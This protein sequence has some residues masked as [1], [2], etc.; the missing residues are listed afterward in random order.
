MSKYYEGPQG[1]ASITRE[2]M[3]DAWLAF[4]RDYTDA[5]VKRTRRVVDTACVVGGIAFALMVGN[6]AKDRVDNWGEGLIEQTQA[7]DAI[8]NDEALALSSRPDF[9]VTEPL[10]IR[11]P[12]EIDPGIA[13]AATVSVTLSCDS[14]AGY[15]SKTQQAGALVI[16]KN[17]TE[18]VTSPRIFSTPINSDK[19]IVDAEIAEGTPDQ[20]YDGFKIKLTLSYFEP[21]MGATDQGPVSA[22]LPEWAT[23]AMTDAIQSGRIQPLI[24]PTE[25]GPPGQLEPSLI[26]GNSGAIVLRNPE[27]GIGPHYDSAGKIMTAGFSILDAFSE[28]VGFRTAQDV[29]SQ[30]EAAAVLNM[31]KVANVTNEGFGIIDDIAGTCSKY[32]SVALFRPD[33]GLDK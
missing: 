22:P 29:C 11:T 14:K 3:D 4:D 27:T 10:I 19:C 30:N 2:E 25:L 24:I 26:H 13:N 32:G 9:S 12:R 17:Q 18:L 6:Y 1:R 7:E 28:I 23:T 33:L 15:S 5:E 20:E 8:I 31:D 16:R 21:F